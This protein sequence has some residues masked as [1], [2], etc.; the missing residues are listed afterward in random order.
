MSQSTPPFYVGFGL[1][2]YLAPMPTIA[3]NI[4]TREGFQW[5]TQIKFCNAGIVAQNSFSQLVNRNSMQKK[6]SPMNRV[7]AQAAGP[8]ASN[9]T[10]GRVIHRVLTVNGSVPPAAGVADRRKFRSGHLARGLFTA[11]NATSL[12]KE[13]INY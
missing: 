13:G 11:A 9:P 12:P 4:P 3:V 1:V 10:T 7:D 5:R 6:V 8:S 2:D